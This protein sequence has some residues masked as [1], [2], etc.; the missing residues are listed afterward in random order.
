[1]IE[2]WNGDY[3]FILFDQ[4]EIASA[5]N[6]YAISQWLPGYEVIGLRGWDDFILRDSAGQTFSVPTVPAV[7]QDI[8]PFTLPDSSVALVPDSRYRNSIKWYAQPVVFGGDPNIGKNLVWI[9]HDQHAEA[10]K[11]WN[12]FYHGM[13]GKPQ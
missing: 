3:Y 8:E 13:K 9:T 12:E 4:Q 2:G 1:M 6:R 5:S 10:V 7:A 11:Y